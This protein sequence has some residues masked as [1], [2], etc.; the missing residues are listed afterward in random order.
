[1]NNLDIIKCALAEAAEEMQVVHGDDVRLYEDGYS[2]RGMFGM[3]TW[4]IVVPSIPCA[5]EFGQY[6]G[7]AMVNND[8]NEIIAFNTDSLGL[9]T[10]VYITDKRFWSKW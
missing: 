5:I 6:L 1:M 2:G 3:K 4:G 9:D 8:C 7:Q 10:I